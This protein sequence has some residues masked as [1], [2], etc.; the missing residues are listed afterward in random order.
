MREDTPLTRGPISRTGKGLRGLQYAA[1]AAILIAT[2][3]TYQLA[4]TSSTESKWGLEAAVS[5]SRSATMG[6]PTRVVSPF[7]RT[8]LKSKASAISSTGSMSH[9]AQER[10]SFRP[11]SKNLL[12][13]RSVVSQA[14]A[15]SLEEYVKERGGDRPIKR[16]LIAN[17]G[18][19]AT[20]AMLSMRQWAFLT[21]GDVNAIEFV[22]MATP[23]DL[24]ANAE[25]IRLANEY[26]EVPG[27]KNSNNY[28]NVPLICK[29]AQEQGV[30]A[31]WPG[32]GHASE[33]PELPDSLDKIGVKFIGP[34]GRV[35]S[36]LGD[37]IAANILAQTAE[38]PSIPWSG[39]GL[40]A[41]LNEE[42]RIPDEIFNKAMV[43][44]EE[45]AVAAAERIGFPVMLKASEGGGGKGIRMSD[46][47]EELRTNFVQ[48]SNEVPGSPMFMMQLCKEARHLEVQIVG[49]AHGNAVALNGRDCST[50]RR[51]QKI[52]EEGPPIIASK[53]TFQLMERA[54][55]RLT[56]S[57]GYQG[58][59]TVEYLFNAATGKFYFLELNPR[60]QVEHPVTE[61]ITGINMPAT[62]LQVA[63][64]IPLTNIP[65]VQRFY[66]RDPS[67]PT[68]EIDF[69]TEEYR[70][71]D[72]HVIAARI[73]AE[74]PDDGFKPTS[75][76]IE[77]INF[78]S[79]PRV[80]GY[81][82][83]GANGGIHEFADSQFGHLFA[84]GPTREEA[85]KHLIL[86]LRELD[87]KGD[88]RTAVTY[89]GELLQTPAFIDNT[90]DTSWLDGLIKEKQVKQN[91][92][93]QEVVLASA[94]ARAYNQIKS[95]MSKS[96]EALEK[97]QTGLADLNSVNQFPI[98]ITY[99]DVKYHFDA[100]RM[101]PDTLRF[102]VNGGSIDVRIREQ[103]DGS[104]LMKYGGYTHKVSAL[105]EPLGLRLTLDG[106]TIIVPTVFDPSELRSDITG[107]I[108]RYLHSE[109]D[110]V[111]QG[112][113]Y[114]EVEA[115]KMIMSFPAGETGKI[116]HEMSPGSVIGAGD[117][118]ASLELKDPSKVK[119][120][121]PF[122]GQLDSID[123]LQDEAGKDDRAFTLLDNAING[124]T[125]E[126]ADKL[127]AE[128]IEG[129]TS[130]GEAFEKVEA[131]VSLFVSM[132]ERF[133]GAVDLDDVILKF[134]RDN[135]DQLQTV[136]DTIVAH[137]N[138]KPR[139]QIITSLLR[140]VN[141]NIRAR[142]EDPVLP[143]NLLGSLRK[144]AQLQGKGYGQVALDAQDTLAQWAL[145][146]FSERL[147]RLRNELVQTS[148]LD[149]LSASPILSAGVDLLGQLFN[150]PDKEV[151]QKAL[152]VYALRTYRPYRIIEDGV[153]IDDSQEGGAE[154]R[155]KYK[156]ASTPDAQ[157]PVRE[158]YMKVVP[159]LDQL[160]SSLSAMSLPF[161]KVADDA[162][163]L[164]TVHISFSDCPEIDD[165]AL[166][167]II[168]RAE[169]AVAANAEFKGRGIRNIVLMFNHSPS[170]PRYLNLVYCNGFKEDPLRRDM[171]P[172]FPHIF[173]L[174]RMEGNFD[175]QRLPTNNPFTHLYLGSEKTSKPTRR[176][177]PQS[178]FVRSFTNEA[179]FS[180]VESAE[181][182]MVQ[183][184]DEAERALLNPKILPTVSSRI[185]V[186]V[187]PEWEASTED[188]TRRFKTLREKLVA[189]YSDRLLRLKIDEFEI[190]VNQRESDGSC[191]PLRLVASSLGGQL[192][193]V[194][195]YKEEISPINGVPTRFSL[196][197]PET[198]DESRTLEPYAASDKLQAKR[199]NARRIGTTYAYDFLT[200]ME[201]S[202]LRRWE[203]HLGE[204]M[205]SSI[206][207]NVFEA[208]E[209]LLDRKT[210][211]LKE[212][213]QVTGTND[214]AMV[215][216]R[217]TMK[218]PEYPEGREIVLIANDITLQ[219]GSFG[220]NEDDFFFK[221]SELARKEGLPR[222]FISA[223]SGARIGL[224]EDLKPKFKAAWNNPEEP[225]KGFQYL[226]LSEA[227][228][229]ELPEGSV[230]AEKKEVDG[231]TRYALQ[232]IVGDEKVH[233]IG[234]E[235]LRGSGMI[236]GETSRAYDEVFT[237][238]YVTG[239]SVGIGAYLNRLGQR[240]IQMQNGPMILTGFS[241]LNKLLG[242]DVYSSQDQLGGPQIMYPNG[243]THDV[244]TNDREGVDR[245]IDWLS[246]VPKTAQDTVPVIEA[247]DPVSRPVAFK[248]T[249]TPYD[250]RNMLQ[251]VENENGEWTS[252]FFDKGSFH[253]TLGGW[254]KSVI[255][256]RGK[257]GG[258][259]V[260][261][262]AVE[263]RLVD[264][265]IPAD[266]AN[267]ASSET[268][269]QQAGQV[270]FPDSA[271]KTAQA[272]EDFARGENLPLIIFANWRGFSGG[273]RD[274]YNEVLKF[275]AK[276]VDALRKYDQ[277][278]F[279]YI[280]PAGELRGGAW[281]VVDPTINPEHM[282]MYA[283]VESRGGILEPPGICEVKFREGDQVKTMQRLDPELSAL[284]ER[285]EADPDNQELRSAIKSREDKLKPIYLNIAHEFADLHD[286][287]GRM[288]A[289]GV[290]RDAL[291]WESSREFFH[292]RIRRRVQELK[293]AKEMQKV[294][295][296]LSVEE[297]TKRV[298]T[299]LG[300]A[301]VEDDKAMVAALDAGAEK[302]EKAKKD[303]RQ[304]A[305][306]AQI[307]KLQAELT[308]SSK[309]LETAST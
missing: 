242:R 253:E 37:K 81:F 132:E 255:V 28:A 177:S 144:L 77:R 98:D 153:Q 239:R 6:L 257:L 294:D 121:L 276:I 280:P 210:M 212:G 230:V 190:K 51:F 240:T 27:G 165:K 21:L 233:G 84:S 241:A 191:S 281:V 131:L 285:L 259:P 31:V 70:D 289:K 2:F 169:K 35:M 173:E 170:Q 24:N 32:W 96:V 161:D 83:V 290:I 14:T 85:R 284:C 154:A 204:N 145:G 300:V 167:G 270:W 107:K 147:A 221:A 216:W 104:L 52:F 62:Q 60:L 148:N 277:P 139:A 120:I 168:E 137:R 101:G 123:Q 126:N 226:Y 59:G 73:T 220:V 244:V 217:C 78:K 202:I 57:I 279:I 227:D 86:A 25:F 80:W 306:K 160:E 69:M 296:S 34:G 112:E 196:I 134:A 124:F 87:V 143:E 225:D 186:H 215:A 5:A 189:K 200:L 99:E 287:A 22:A 174:S 263:T 108:V 243:V 29:V 272:I 234:V 142:F 61:G 103:P 286:R 258:V 38:V 292:W 288:K 105:E 301:N 141:N 13:P 17:N 269:E 211:E 89:L 159:S 219:S 250:P 236:A 140:A 72:N 68:S 293:W 181:K 79:T 130:A 33:K 67:Q 122:E 18:M 295:S 183:C 271:F 8:A 74:N 116:K 93:P 15:A 63:M 138:L 113:P 266:P 110:T 30:D 206:P 90:I 249:K 46:N 109:G 197:Y 94:A 188:I 251:G 50:Q 248:P 16:I 273:T 49:D 264:R 118:L 149:E 125:T 150:D 82:S 26:V 91:T 40:K 176:P 199:A 180:S 274:M 218:T 291:S 187:Q 222:I 260:G 155:F 42:G 246:Y 209:L 201:M 20:K 164:N 129:A 100:Q 238:S 163:P 275:G 195:A 178:L 133:A 41:D 76:R 231:E 172:A 302:L 39:D 192:F 55:Q 308:A 152:K 198:A 303:V 44:T 119:K 146:T 10:P 205:A 278:I 184:L 56:Q 127:I 307:E 179:A 267:P 213:S 299:V 97:G 283:D 53:D 247:K 65:D 114:V 304:A 282:E 1:S 58:A 75:G 171:R 252:G 309:E 262:V 111:E 305:I 175:L 214:I 182:M 128:M 235:N 7:M 88:I 297:A 228:Y 47:V 185:F 261:C 102:T 95:Q 64:G 256:G 45:E 54:A 203:D 166:S 229:N 135:K 158:A 48:V 162:E 157:T 36:L 237:L 245:I 136:I 115:M 3:V 117:L 193:D 268:I 156:Y 4:T 66:G 232:A 254:G 265:R 224:Y 71:I 298:Q 43:T 151:R 19:A 194:K 9:I 12:K 106:Q 92:N 223:N 23:E 11:E 207:P 208:K